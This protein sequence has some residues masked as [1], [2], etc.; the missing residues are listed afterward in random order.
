MSGDLVMSGARS[1]EGCHA[2][3]SLYA[4]SSYHLYGAQVNQWRV[5]AEG[6]AARMREVRALTT[7][8]IGSFR[9]SQPDNPFSPDTLLDLVTPLATHFPGFGGTSPLH[10]G[11][12][13]TSYLE[14]AV[15]K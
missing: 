8:E 11:H 6:E 12:Q 7:I 14:A 1:D 5:R 2:I 15:S 9:R 4:N 13:R 10:H 3:E